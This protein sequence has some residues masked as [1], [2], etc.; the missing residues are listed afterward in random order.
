MVG[1]LMFLGCP[2]RML[3]RL[4]GGD[5][6]ALVALAGFA[7]GIGV[8]SLALKKGFS[9]RRAYAQPMLEGAAFPI[10]SA[11]VLLASVAMPALFL[12]STEGPGSMHAPVLAALAQRS[13]FCMAGGLRD[14]YL[15]RDM[16]LLW[17]SI[18]LLAVMVVGDLALGKWNLGFEG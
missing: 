16:H 10:A 2:L 9:L 14:V 7:A 3:L 17:G 18:A 12:F 13:R 15:F 5:L 6:N 4:G 11:L 1:A 8:G